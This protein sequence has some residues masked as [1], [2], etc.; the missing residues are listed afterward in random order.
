MV[1]ML[2]ETQI[3]EL[4]AQLAKARGWKITHAARMASGSGDTVSRIEGGV[5]LT[6]RRANAIIE[7]CSELWPIGEPW[8]K[9]IPR[10]TLKKRVA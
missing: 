10:P 3:A 2:T 7:K 1:H 5:G 6:I 4:I 8:P 9:A